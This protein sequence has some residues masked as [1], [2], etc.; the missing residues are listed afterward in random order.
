MCAD[1]AMNLTRAPTAARTS[2]NASSWAPTTSLSAVSMPSARISPGATTVSVPRATVATH[3]LAVRRALLD[4]AY[5]SHLT[6]FRLTVAVSL[7][8]ARGLKDVQA[9][10]NVS[11]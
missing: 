11:R 9:Q 2:T 6:S 10:P 8:G 5:A 3:L 7:V 4:P 1:E